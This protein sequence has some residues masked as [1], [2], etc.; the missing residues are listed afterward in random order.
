[1]AYIKNTW[2]DQE[3]ERPRTYQKEDHADGSFTLID[4]FGL[5]SELGTPVNAD[6]M[7]HIEE[8]IGEHEERITALENLPDVYLKTNQITNC[9]TEIPQ[10]IKTDVVD[11][12]LTVYAGTVAIVPY[13]TEDRTSEFPI[14]STFIHENFKVVDT[15]FETSGDAS[16]KFLVWVEVQ[17]NIVVSASTT[18]TQERLLELNI[19]NNSTKTVVN[20]TSSNVAY[21]GTG[22]SANYRTDLNIIQ[23]HEAG[24]LQDEVLSFPIMRVKAD[25]T[26]LLGSISQ[27]FNGIGY[28]GTY[29]WKEKDI[30][31]LSPNGFNN[32]GTLANIEWKTDKC[33]GR[34]LSGSGTFALFI[35][36]DSSIDYVPLNTYELTS[37]PS[38]TCRRYYNQIDN[39]IHSAENNTIRYG[40]VYIGT[41][42]ISDGKI[43]SF[44]VKQPFR[45]VDYND[46]ETNLDGQWVAVNKEI[47]SGK[48]FAINTY[49]TYN[50][51]D[52]LPKD[53]HVYDCIFRCYWEA[54]DSGNS[55]HILGYNSIPLVFGK[56]A[57]WGDATGLVPVKSGG[58][59]KVGNLSS[60]KQ[61]LWGVGL[62]L[63]AYRKAR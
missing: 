19:S 62:R 9:I 27:V 3:V 50:A 1:M 32:D 42:T 20:T 25:G 2:V 55:M 21:S 30:V 35:S 49:S 34:Q 33:I 54:S 52:I 16:G 22:N 51:N 59:Y 14:G 18:D 4:D 56:T 43:T 13:G 39:Y 15:Q 40:Y 41:C 28:I 44:D 17:N 61:N 57:Y 53:G 26:N 46:L 58:T 12:T 5:V 60:S 36:K 11:G 45:A 48:S 29:T 8:G 47:F 63:V 24:V 23:Y 6:N 31:G 7:N 10:R 37:N 38:S